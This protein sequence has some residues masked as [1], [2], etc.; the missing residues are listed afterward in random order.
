MSKFK[1][2]NDLILNAVTHRGG[3]SAA[4]KVKGMYRGAQTDRID[5][6]PPE[7]PDYPPG[8]LRQLESIGEETEDVIEWL[9][10][11][12]WGEDVESLY[13]EKLSDVISEKLPYEFET[14]EF[15]PRLYAEFGHDGEMASGVFKEIF[16]EAKDRLAEAFFDRYMESMEENVQRSFEDGPW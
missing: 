9:K 3:I 7:P 1:Q 2:T 10:E 12:G 13:Q 4:E 5:A 16:S 6:M 14:D 8:A 15:I 11:G